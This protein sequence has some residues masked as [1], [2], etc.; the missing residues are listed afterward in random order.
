MNSKVGPALACLIVA[1]AIH[2][3]AKENADLNGRVLAFFDQ[4]CADCHGPETQKHGLSL[5]SIQDTLAGSTMG[6]VVVPGNARDSLLVQIIGFQEQTNAIVIE[7]EIATLF[8]GSD[9]PADC[10]PSV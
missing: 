1:Q 6:A 5:V 2:A 7:T 4:Q 8:A 9:P 3:G 10:R